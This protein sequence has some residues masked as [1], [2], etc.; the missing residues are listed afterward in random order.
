MVLYY[1]CCSLPRS[2]TNNPMRTSKISILTLLAVLIF[3]CGAK[4]VFAQTS[5]SV[6]YIPLIGITSLP[7]PLSL[8]KGPGNVTY[9]YAVKN[10]LKEAPI[11]N[12]Q[13]TDSKC[14]PITFIEGDDNDNSKLDYNET[15]RYDCTIKLFE[16]TQS[17]ATVTGTANN[18]PASHKAYAT[19]VV[20]SDAVAPFVNIVNITKVA[21]PLTLPA[22]GGDITFTYRVSNPGVIPLSNIHITDDK[23]SAMSNKLGDTN[24]N[25]LLDI[26]EVWIYTCT[27]HL[28]QTTT[29]TASISSY[30]NGLNAVGYATLTVIVDGP[31][32]A[33]SI[34]KFPDV[35]EIDPNV[36]FSLWGIFTVILAVLSI[37][38]FKAPKNKSGKG[39]KK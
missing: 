31:A 33:Q 21:Y 25:N 4:S 2:V 14:S 20:G 9:H 28:T 8:P 19:V 6:L 15:W 34:P 29:N 39:H 22:T 27:T 23:C 13:I 24:G 18:L 37:Y 35:G 12:V 3:G 32:V 16:T 7:E 30:A 26:T 1:E 10:F 5:P 17:T 38:F 11:A 36:K